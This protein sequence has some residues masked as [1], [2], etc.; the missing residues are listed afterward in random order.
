MLLLYLAFAG[1]FAGELRGD[2][3]RDGKIAAA[4]EGNVERGR[5]WARKATCRWRRGA[6]RLRSRCHGGLGPLWD[7]VSV[8]SVLIG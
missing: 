1:A 6:L 2:R 8:L 4:V 7:A 5:T 3:K